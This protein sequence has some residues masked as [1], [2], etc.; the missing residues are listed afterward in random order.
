MFFIV[1]VNFCQVLTDFWSF[2]IEPF[3]GGF[4]I[5]FDRFCEFTRTSLN[6][7]GRVLPFLTFLT[8]FHNP[9]FSILIYS[10]NLVAASNINLWNDALI[11]TIA[12][13]RDSAY[14]DDNEDT[15]NKLLW[16]LVIK[17]KNHTP[18]K[19]YFLVKLL[20]GDSESTTNPYQR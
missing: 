15:N 10:L 5:V 18:L 16:A 20:F 6:V 1:L 4:L 13:N 17:K 19:K 12:E 9:I 3:S 11:A 2:L 8:I 7:F 14:D